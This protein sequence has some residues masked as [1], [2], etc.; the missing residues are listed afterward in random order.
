M[1]KYHEI[2]TQK[3]EKACYSITYKSKRPTSM[4]NFYLHIEN[5]MK[6]NRE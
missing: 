2:S 6:F 1:Q 5:E 4:S 3:H